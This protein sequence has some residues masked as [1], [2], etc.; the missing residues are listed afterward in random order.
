M[1]ARSILI[2]LFVLTIALCRVNALPSP[3]IEAAGVQPN[4]LEIVGTT[5]NNGEQANVAQPQLVQSIYHAILSLPEQE[6]QKVCPMYITAQYQLTFLHGAS[7]LLTA[8]IKQGGCFTV[9]FRQG[10]VRTVNRNFLA[11][12]G[13]THALKSRGSLSHAPDGFGPDDL[14]GAYALPGSPA[15]KGQTVA[16]V[17][18]N[19]DPNA[20]A[21]LRVYRAT[22]HLPAC[23]AASRCFRKVNQNGTTHYPVADPAW[24]P[25]IAL[26][27][28]MVSAICPACHI[29][30]VEANSASFN[31]LGTA[32]NTAVRLGANVVSNSYGSRENLSDATRM[33]HYYNH[34]GVIITASSG[35]NGYGVQL[36]AAFKGV[37]AVGGTTL[38]RANNARGWSESVWGGSGSGCSQ[39]ISKPAWQ[40]NSLCK[41]RAVADVAAV[42]DPD[43]GVATYNSYE[44]YDTNWSVSGGTSAASPIIAATYA[45]AGNAAKMNG[46]YLYRHTADLNDITTGNNG[47]CKPALLCTGGR[48]YNGPTGFG[49]PKGIGAF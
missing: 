40:K 18:S 37:V 43:T 5:V 25:E 7:S 49:T 35:D 28:D 12:L 2:S 10:D 20:E 13:R 6:A 48:G 9:S 8:N 44:S 22:F 41:N 45:L 36:P 21:D 34:P 23:T 1:N 17:D 31:D 3:A 38:N 32:V 29:L 39:Y 19:D 27:L 24:A 30:L 33:A 47:T 14:Q 11:L 26:D 15:G 4:M 42:A 16:I 46:A